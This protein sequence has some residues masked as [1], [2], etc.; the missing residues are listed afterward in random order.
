MFIASTSAYTLTA[1]HSFYGNL[2]YG[3]TNNREKLDIW[4]PTDPAGPLS[5][6]IYFHGGGFVGGSKESI[7]ESTVEEYLNN[8]FVVVS[9][10]YPFVKRQ[11]DTS[12]IIDTLASCKRAIQFL[13]FYKDYFNINVDNLFLYGGSA[14]AS[15]SQWLG[16]QQHPAVDSTIDGQGFSIN[17]ISL[18]RP[19]ATL[20]TLRYDDIFQPYIPN[21]SVKFAYDRD[22]NARIETNRLYGNSVWYEFF[23]EPYISRRASMDMM[24]FIEAGNTCK[25]RIYCPDAPVTALNGIGNLPDI[26]HSPFM[27]KTTYDLLKAQGETVIADINGILDDTAGVSTLNFFI[28]NQV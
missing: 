11:E 4:V 10:T 8:D 21:F 26:V 14:G 15:I 1:N 13:V 9:C 7:G 20:D 25:T 23:I 22:A 16:Y 24:A 17:A 2:Q 27:G 12:G 5:A 6:Y 19:Q 3:V 18:F 28:A